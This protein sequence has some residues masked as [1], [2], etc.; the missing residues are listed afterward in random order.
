MSERGGPAFAVLVYALSRVAT[1]EARTRLRRHLDSET[2]A[3]VRAVIASGLAGDL[4]S[5][6][7][8]RVAPPAPPALPVSN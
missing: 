2:D 7:T 3:E 6:S 8:R 4:D 5:A 1:P